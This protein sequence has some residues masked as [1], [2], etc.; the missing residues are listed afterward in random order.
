MVSFDTAYS[1]VSGSEKEEEGNFIHTTLATT[2]VEG[3]NIL[4]VV[5]ADRVVA[6]LTSR[7]ES[8]RKSK[9]EPPEYESE[10]E[11][12]IL[13]LGSRFE[14]LRVAGFEIGVELHHELFLK[15]D[16][17]DEVMKEFEENGEFWKMAHPP[18]VP[19]QS[20]PKLPKKVDR[21][22]VVCCSLVKQ[23]EPAKSPGFVYHGH[24]GHVLDVPEFGK[25]HLAEVLCEYGRKTLT[26]LRVDLGSPNGGAMVVAQGGSNGRPPAG[27]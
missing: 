2:V 9:V 19:G 22:G 4:D 23:L 13:I 21:H 14:N 5:T 1:Q 27:P 18:V 3:L 10:P 11:S 6:R 17:F 26:M 25:I 20:R 12:H 7:H 8:R 24:Y 15:L 16:T